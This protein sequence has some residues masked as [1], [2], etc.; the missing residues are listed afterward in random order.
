MA[1]EWQGCDGQGLDMPARNTPQQEPMLAFEVTGQ[2]LTME[3]S[4]CRC[5]NMGRQP[6]R[7]S[8]T[9]ASCT[10]NLLLASQPFQPNHAQPTS[11]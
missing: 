7:T 4:R 9:V 10:H 8:A 6:F 2:D 1:R 11:C 3:R 5:S